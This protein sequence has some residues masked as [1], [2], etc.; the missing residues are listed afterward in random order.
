VVGSYSYVAKRLL[1]E[2]VA[3]AS[4][5]SLDNEENRAPTP[6][7]R[8]TGDG[9]HHT[10][11]TFGLL[12]IVIASGHTTAPPSRHRINNPRRGTSTRCGR[13]SIHRD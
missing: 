6:N 9:L 2:A 10:T 4:R 13:G 3:P 1:Y 11:T 7:Q 5:S 8:N 12:P